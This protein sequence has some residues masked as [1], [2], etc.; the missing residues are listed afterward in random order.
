M[1]DLQKRKKL[2]DIDLNKPGHDF[3]QIEIWLL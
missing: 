1:K 2:P 3:L